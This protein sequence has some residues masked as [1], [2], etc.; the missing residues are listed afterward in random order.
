MKV[1]VVRSDFGRY[2]NAFKEN[3]YVAIGWFDQLIDK[4]YSR[5]DIKE[6]RMVSTV[7]RQTT[8]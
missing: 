2:T 7:Y 1:Y 8:S 6:S 5:E 4:S 3:N